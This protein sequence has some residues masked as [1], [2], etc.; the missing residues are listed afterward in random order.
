MQ[1]LDIDRSVDIS[2]EG[3]LLLRQAAKPSAAKESITSSWRENVHIS[4]GFS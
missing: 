1:S 4:E 2:L 3:V